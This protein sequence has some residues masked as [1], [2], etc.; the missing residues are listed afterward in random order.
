MAK[1]TNKEAEELKDEKK[2]LI[3]FPF[4]EGA[5]DTLYYS[6]NGRDFYIDSKTAMSEGIEVPGCLLE[7]IKNSNAQVVAAASKS[8]ELASVGSE[9]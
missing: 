6:V 4:D 1:T 5:P 2:T 9:I 3:V 7:V 8:K